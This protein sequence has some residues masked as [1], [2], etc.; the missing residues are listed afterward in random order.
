[1]A[2]KSNVKFLFRFY[3]N[4]L[5]SV[6]WQD[7]MIFYIEKSVKFPSKLKISCAVYVCNKPQFV[8]YTCILLNTVKYLWTTLLLPKL[9]FQAVVVVVIKSCIKCF[10]LSCGSYF[11]WW[12]FYSL[13]L[14]TAIMILATQ[15]ALS[16]VWYFWCCLKTCLFY[17]I[18]LKST[19]IIY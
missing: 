6:H 19:C 10:C 13:P 15:I 12:Y 16:T 1:M 18:F 2:T 9:L 8:V 14:L 5:C 4:T 11:H 7:K 3:N 17:Y